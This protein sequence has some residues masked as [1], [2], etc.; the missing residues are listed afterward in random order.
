MGEPIENLYFNWLCA[1]VVDSDVRN[2]YDL[3]AILHRTEF[4][5]L[6]HSDGDRA[7]DGIELRRD[8]LRESRMERDLAWES[9]PCSILEFMIALAKRANFQT[10]TPVKDWF[11]E[12]ME[13]L[14]LDEYRRVHGRDSMEI[15]DIL[16]AFIWRQYEPNGYGGMFPISRTQHDQRE[17]E[18]W[19]QFSEYVIDRGLF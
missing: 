13:N 3:L 4:V 8:F 7:A 5:W 10:E 12:F 6:I 14:K 9:E 2:Y 11:W 1:K 18:I 15:E 17:I 16:Y 19:Y